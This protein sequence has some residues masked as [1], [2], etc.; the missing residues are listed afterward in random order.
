MNLTDAQ[1]EAVRGWITAGMKL[2]EIQDR[3]ATEFNI[4]MTY[5]EVRLLVDDLKVMPKDPEPPPAPPKPTPDANAPAASGGDSATKSTALGKV[6]VKFDQ[7]TMPGAVVSGS[8]T[9]SDGQAAQWYLTETGQLGLAPRQKGY[10]PSAADVQAFQQELSRA[11][12]QYG[13]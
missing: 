9:F 2:S 3:L 13:L 5:M 12:E 7:V 6:T 11:L 1:K 4:R 8:V 10:R